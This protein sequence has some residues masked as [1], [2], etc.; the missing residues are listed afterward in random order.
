MTSLLDGLLDDL[1]TEGDE[2]FRTVDRLGTDGWTRATPA[3]GWTVA[4][5]VAHL[6]WTDEVAVLAAQAHETT[7]AKQAWDEVVLAAIN[8]PLGYV[9]VG[10]LRGRPAAPRRGARSVGGG[11]AGPP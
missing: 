5:Q 8:N 9:D 4:T 6:L 3:P 10:R 7:E 1:T 11:Q 2:L